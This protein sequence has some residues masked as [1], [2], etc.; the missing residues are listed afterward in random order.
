MIFKGKVIQIIE[1]KD[2]KRFFYEQERNKIKD[3]NFVVVLAP[4]LNFPLGFWSFIKR[5][6]LRFKHWNDDWVKT[7]LL[8]ECHLKVGDVVKL[9]LKPIIE[10]KQVKLG[11]NPLYNI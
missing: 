8:D 7:V 5:M 2:Y 1:K 9:E 3:K 11:E 10:K 4:D 6:Y